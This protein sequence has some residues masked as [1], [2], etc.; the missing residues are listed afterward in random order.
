M[1]CDNDE[2]TQISDLTE[3]VYNRESHKQKDTEKRLMVYIKTSNLISSLY[4]SDKYFYHISKINNVKDIL[5]KLGNFR[6]KLRDNEAVCE[7]NPNEN[8]PH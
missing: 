3:G 5:N 2:I 4:V 8:Y 6:I 7:E 1:Y